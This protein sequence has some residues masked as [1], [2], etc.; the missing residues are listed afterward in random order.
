MAYRKV[1]EINPLSKKSI[2]NA[3]RE[4]RDE[5]K[6]I[7]KLRDEF[8]L[9]L[10]V[11]IE[12]YLNGI[13]NGGDIRWFN[14]DYLIDVEPMPNG[15]RVTAKG[16]SVAF[17]EFGA[18]IHAGNGKYELDHP[19]FYPGSYSQDHANTYWIWEHSNTPNVEYRW[20]QEALHGFDGVIDNMHRWVKETADEVFK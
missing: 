10:G 19:E 16:E 4:L 18:G 14:Q 9:K 17:I 1:I 2:N 6:Q 7:E 8:L 12:T 11:R 15:L 5:K 3:I 13:Y 20:N